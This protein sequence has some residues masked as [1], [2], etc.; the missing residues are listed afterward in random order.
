MLTVILAWFVA[1]TLLMMGYTLVWLFCPLL[2]D[3][4]EAPAQRM[5]AAVTAEPS[6]VTRSKAVDP[7]RTSSG[8]LATAGAPRGELR[9]EQSSGWDR[10]SGVQE[11][12]GIFETS[13]SLWDG[14]CL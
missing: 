7:T 5:L 14:D 4:M 9:Q 1:V 12:E 2:R 8:R 3:R 6:T 11:E 10:F 13:V